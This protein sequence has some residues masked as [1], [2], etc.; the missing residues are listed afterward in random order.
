MVLYVDGEAVSHTLLAAALDWDA[1]YQASFI[2]G[3]PLPD[4]LFRGSFRGV[5][6]EVRVWSV[7]RAADEI[8]AGMHAPVAA[9]AEGLAAYWNF[10]EG[11]GQVARDLTGHG[12]DAQLGSGP[13]PAAD[14]PLWIRSD[15]PIGDLAKVGAAGHDLW[16][17]GQ[18]ARLLTEPLTRLRLAQALT[19]E[20]WIRPSAP[21]SR[22][23]L[24]SVVGSSGA[25]E[26]RVRLN[27]DGS[28]ECAVAGSNA[29]RQL[30][31]TP[32]VVRPGQWQHVALVCDGETISLSVGGR[33]VSTQNLSEP[34]ALAGERAVVGA[35][36]DGNEPFA[37]EMDELRLWSV[38][39]TDA[40]IG[41]AMNRTI[42]ATESGL[43]AYW[44]FDEGTGKIARDLSPSA[45]HAQLGDMPVPDMNDPLWMVS[46]AP[47][48]V[49]VAAEAPPSAYRNFALQFDG[50]DDLVD[51]GNPYDL[52]F[53]RA[54]TVETWIK[55]ADVSKQMAILAKEN[56][57][58]R[59]N[60]YGLELFQAMARFEISDGS[61]GCCGAQGWFPA[62]GKTPLQPGLWRHVAGVY[63][64][65]QLAVYLDGILEGTLTFD[66]P[67]ADVPFTFKIGFN[68]PGAPHYFNGM[69]DEVRLWNRARSQVEILT[70]MSRSLRGNEPGLVGYWTFD[71]PARESATSPT[72]QIAFDGSGRQ[73][74]GFLG[75][76]IKPEPSDP[77]WV[78]SDAPVAP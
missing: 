13:V 26:L 23:C 6:D 25:G 76:T 10:D 11:S 37:G 19:I 74:H 72:A 42:A 28:F 73:N 36:A 59:Q 22:A 75:G 24:V 62:T 47:I 29:A 27:E 67:I 66:H 56:A 38:A 58:G 53:F 77:R 70:D 34:V 41:E 52:R 1:G 64:C 3:D 68:A 45:A 61:A 12:H 40:Q 5:I 78:P 7:P 17:N 4:P 69:I 63:D 21:L 60:S 51:M 65:K 2:G 55:P 57:N 71:E 39:R 46:D 20:A 30:I 48:T 33:S 14:D 15:C 16:F 44:R 54:V 9:N 18:T 35:A 49:A 43:A 8:R 31:R 50:V 32:P